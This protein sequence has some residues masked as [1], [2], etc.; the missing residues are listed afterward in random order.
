[1]RAFNK[2]RTFYRFRWFHDYSG[3]QVT[4]F[5]VHYMDA[6]QWALG[7]DAPLAVTAMGGKLVIEDN[8]EIPDTLEVLWTY[9][10]GTLVTF[11]Q[12]NATA[13]PAAKDRRVEIEFRG[14]KGTL[15][16]YSDGYEIVPDVITPNEFPART[17]VDRQLERGYRVGAKPQIEARSRTGGDADTAHHARNFLD[18]VKSRAAC[19]CDIETGHRSTSATLIANVAH[20]TKSYLEWDRAAERFTNN[21]K[22][23]ALLSYRYRAPYEAPRT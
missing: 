7:H 1:M 20:K 17:P 4:N 19:N 13:A 9:P 10:G 21:E 11:S 8:R 6:I 22:A 5:G 23:N 16:L 2:N 18:C 3:G 15:Y 12:Y 14:T